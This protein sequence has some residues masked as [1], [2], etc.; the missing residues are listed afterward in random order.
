MGPYLLKRR[1]R[2]VRSVKIN[3]LFVAQK[4]TED[5][6]WLPSYF[7]VLEN[8]RGETLYVSE[9]Q[10]GSLYNVQF[11]ELPL[12]H[13]SL[14]YFILKLFA[15]VPKVL[16]P[17]KDSVWCLFRCYHVDLNKM[18]YLKPDDV[19]VSYNAPLLELVDGNYILTEAPVMSSPSSP[20]K[21]HKRGVSSVKIKHS[22]TFNNVL[23][24]NKIL[25]YTSQVMEESRQISENLEK[26]MQNEHKKHKWLI[27]S[28]KSYNQ[29]MQARIQRKR[30]DLKRLHSLLKCTNAELDLTLDMHANS[31]ND[32]YGNTYPNLIQKRDKLETLRTKKLI[33]LIGIFQTTALFHVRTGFVTFDQSLQNASV[34]DRLSLELLNKDDLVELAIS[35]SKAKKNLTSTCL[36]YYMMFATLIATRICS[37]PLPHA[38]LYCGSTSVING[39]APLYLDNNTDTAMLSQAIDC[40]NIDILQII[41]YLRHRQAQL[42][43]NQNN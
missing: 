40:F 26:L 13:S 43:G 34:Y 41:Q 20:T 21:G 11:N 23:K 22:F 31:L 8:S 33:Q 19:V 3:N 35:G 17:Y 2:H 4:N 16:S 30:L 27:N 32:Y 6:L 5:Q 42:I 9:V 38:L 36:G 39:T 12:Q 29:Q 15:E 18:Q 25:E 37:I 7:I 14:T 1:L 24:L 28:L 10:H